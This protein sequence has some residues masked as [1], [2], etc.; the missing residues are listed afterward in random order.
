MG[1][2]KVPPPSAISKELCS[3]QCVT[4]HTVYRQPEMLTQCPEFSLEVRGQLPMCLTFSLQAIWGSTWDHTARGP[5]RKLDYLGWPKFPG[6]QTHSSQAEYP[7][8]LEGM[9]QEPIAKSRLSLNRV[10]FFTTHKIIPSEGTRWQGSFLMWYPEKNTS[11]ILW[12]C[13]EFGGLTLDIGS[14]DSSRLRVIHRLKGCVCFSFP[15]VLL[16]YNSHTIQFDHLKCPTQW[17]FQYVYYSVY[18]HMYIYVCT[19]PV[20]RQ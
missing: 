10:Q 1:F 6:K 9:S 18:T 14:T 7:R 15:A 17:C 4:S 3:W 5:H 11:L 12:S 16:R 19:S 8:G 20:A 2:Q 13:Q